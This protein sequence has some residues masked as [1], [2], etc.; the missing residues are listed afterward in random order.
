MSKINQYE[1]SIRNKKVYSENGKQYDNHGRYD[2]VAEEGYKVRDFKDRFTYGSHSV[3]S[4]YMITRYIA[5]T[6][7]EEL[8]ILHHMGGKDYSDDGA[9]NGKITSEAFNKNTLALLLHIADLQATYI[10]ERLIGE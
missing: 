3:N 10:D 1:I 6:Y 7:E 9:D 5:T 4:V 8:A 2:W